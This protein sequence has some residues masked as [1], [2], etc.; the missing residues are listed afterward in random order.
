MARMLTNEAINAWRQRI[1]DH[2]LAG[3]YYEMGVAL[4][5]AGD[6]S[7]ASERFR[8]AID[9]L[10][11]MAEAHFRLVQSLRER[12][13][14]AEA[15]KADQQAR[16]IAPLYVTT[17]RFRIGRDHYRNGRAEAAE[18]ALH[19]ILKEIPNHWEARIYHA[20][21]QAELG[22]AEDAE[23]ALG[24]ALADL[25]PD[26]VELAGDLFDAGRR[27]FG[28]GY[29]SLSHRLIEAAA[30]LSPDDMDLRPYR[31]MALAAIGRTGEADA[32]Y[33]QCMP[34][35]Q[36]VDGGGLMADLLRLGH[37]LLH[38]GKAAEAEWPFRRHLEFAPD[39]AKT[40]TYLGCVLTA[41][42][43][44]DDALTEFQ[45]ALHLDPSSAWARAQMGF[46]L[47]AQ[48]RFEEGIASVRAAYEMENRSAT[49]SASLGIALQNAGRLEEAATLFAQGIASSPGS[50][51]LYGYYGLAQIALG[52]FAG[53][54]ES[55]RA[56]LGHAPRSARLRS[57]LGLAFQAQ[58]HT[59]EA[60]AALREARSCED[61][62]AWEKSCFG[63][64][65]QAQGQLDEAARIQEAVVEA[66]PMNVWS[67]VNLG[68][69]RL[70]QG[71]V[72]DADDAFLRALGSQSET[73]RFQAKLRPWAE[74][75]LRAAFGKL[76][77]TLF[78]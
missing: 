21:T 58:G 17:A 13:A 76:G 40:R 67:L 12:G 27:C 74:A 71:R 73:I 30:T 15:E 62:G 20:L 52:R 34:N 56:G 28:K 25:P 8:L 16:A 39:D 78:P 68:L 72:K 57:V 48:G 14:D 70:D 44:L 31:A 11:D 64:L 41:R 75:S 33:Q 50:A 24:N 53:A 77:F 3:Y 1:R 29:A 59:A 23:A 37:G 42:R 6:L 54:V 66:N 32:L 65:L 10:P 26:D 38:A 7:T 5:N 55:A 2:T 9:I 61:V 4:R 46:A 47:Q 63:L 36:G 45:T 22:R 51:L 69:V 35:R 43:R 19:A 49:G 18:A 60:L